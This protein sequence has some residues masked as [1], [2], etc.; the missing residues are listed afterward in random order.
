MTHR[1]LIPLDVLDDTH[2]ALVKARLSFPDAA[3]FLL[4]VIPTPL[5]T[6]PLAAA[7][8]SAVG[9]TFATGHAQMEA[10]RLVPQARE[11]LKG[12]G[13][14]EV[15]TSGQVVPEIL[16]RAQSGAFDFILMGTAGK[17]GLERFLLGSVAEAVVR[18][19]P[20]PVMTLRAVPAASPQP[21]PV[22]RV[23][24]MHDFSAAAQEAAS[25]VQRHFPGAQID[26]L[27]AVPPGVVGG[28]PQA[29]RRGLSTLILSDHRRTWL[30]QARAR[31]EELGGGEIVEGEPAELALARAGSGAY[32][33]LALG[34]SS[35][36]LLERLTLGSVAQQVVRRAT[37]PVLTVSARQEASGA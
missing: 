37:V 9:A 35:R 34:T 16:R 18:E 29:G 20:I 28:A 11:A 6:A 36:T 24:V 19:S 17:A 7:D 5:T 26:R 10:D 15:V 4:H 32:D 30:D 23:L 22:R 27:H 3:L 1:I 12:L 2:P 13:E 33:L 31:L 14:G 21:A 8:L 25:F